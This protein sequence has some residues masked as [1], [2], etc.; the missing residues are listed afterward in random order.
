MSPRSRLI[1]AVAATLKPVARAEDCLRWFNE[2]EWPEPVQWVL[3]AAR[4]L[5]TIHQADPDANIANDY[6]NLGGLLI[7][8][9]WPDDIQDEERDGR[10]ADLAAQIGLLQIAITAVMKSAYDMG[11]RPAQID[12]PQLDSAV[13]EKAGRERELRGIEGRLDA[14]E[15]VLNERFA[16]EAGDNRPRTQVL[17]VTR[18][19]ALMAR[20]IR[21]MRGALLVGPLLALAL[22][23]RATLAMAQA[24]RD[25]IGTVRAAAS[26]A[27]ESLKS[28]ADAM[29]Q[30]VRRL[31]G[32]IRTLVR[33]V[34]RQEAAPDLP[35]QAPPPIPEDM[36][37]QARAMILAGQAPPAHWTPAIIE[38][39]FHGEENL[40][41]LAPVAGLTALQTLTLANTGVSDLAPVAGIDGLFVLVENEA[42]AAELRATLGKGSKVKVGVRQQRSPDAASGAD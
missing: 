12:I 28:A 42:R 38:L 6:A 36:L 5:H 2:P 40:T 10:V 34:L 25:L 17:I 23:E 21:A 33:R 19:V 11:L 16:G 41:S 27:S 32:G 8:I 29:K 15:R 14:L 31:V 37:D 26:K 9:V 39:D 22:F 20:S 4:E 7:Q 24:T 30:P 35:E 1:A 18:Y 13:V 3:A